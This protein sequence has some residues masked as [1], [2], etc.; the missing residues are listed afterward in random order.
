MKLPSHFLGTLCSGRRTSHRMPVLTKF[1]SQSRLAMAA[2]SKMCIVGVNAYSWRKP[3]RS[4]HLLAILNGALEPGCSR[5]GRDIWHLGA[6]D[7]VA[8]PQL[9]RCNIVQDRL[10]LPA[11]P[12]T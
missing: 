6:L 3:S 11:M 1:R 2:P 5:S 8:R 12:T 7:L 9:N 4:R 10:I